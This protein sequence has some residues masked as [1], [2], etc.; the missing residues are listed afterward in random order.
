MRILVV[1]DTHG[2]TVDLRETVMAQPKAEVV[3]HLGD[4]EDD[5][6]KIKPL[7]P[8]KMFLQVRGNCDFG[9]SLPLADAFVYNGVRIFFTH[10]HYYDVKLGDYDIRRAARERKA[11]ILLYG[12]THVAFADYE[13]G[14]YA[15]NPGSLHGY[16]KSYGYIDITESGIVTNLVRL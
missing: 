1:S 2:D 13:D 4:G 16:G 7:F 14:L 6:A 3:I 10:G 11:D 9:S 5:V 15:M 12:H 8:E